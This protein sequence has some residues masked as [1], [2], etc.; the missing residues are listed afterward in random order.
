MA[1]NKLGKQALRA[2]LLGTGVVAITPMLTPSI[3]PDLFDL[4]VI[5]LG[6]VIGAGLVVFGV[7]W[8]LDQ[9]IKE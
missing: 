2:V 1:D 3:I 7:N 5:T 4:Q 8:I 6:A 9:F